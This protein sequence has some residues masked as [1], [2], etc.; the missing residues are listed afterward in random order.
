MTRGRCQARRRKQV[1]KAAPNFFESA[2]VSQSNC[3]TI[4]KQKHIRDSKRKRS[5]Q[6]HVGAVGCSS[7][8]MIC[9]QSNAFFVLMSSEGSCDQ[10]HS[11]RFARSTF[12]QSTEDSTTSVHV[13]VFSFPSFAPTDISNRKGIRTLSTINTKKR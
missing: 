5:H 7:N 8:C 12:R 13:S 9:Y 3:M 2:D 10:I 6:V 4:H 1:Q 11:V